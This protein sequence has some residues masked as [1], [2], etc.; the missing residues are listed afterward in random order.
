MTNYHFFSLYYGIPLSSTKVMLHISTGFVN[1]LFLGYWCQPM[2]CKNIPPSI[3]RL[4]NRD[5]WKAVI[6]QIK[7]VSS[8]LPSHT[9]YKRGAPPLIARG[10]VNAQ[11]HKKEKSDIPMQCFGISLFY[12]LPCGSLVNSMMSLGVHSNILHNFSNVAV[13]MCLLCFKL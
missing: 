9:V 2:D 13:V 5:N 10:L 7:I 1:V 4:C 3:L 12:F 6:L 8:L 11:R